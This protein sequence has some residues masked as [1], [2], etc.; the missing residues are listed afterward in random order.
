M[1]LKQLR[2]ERRLNQFESQLLAG[3]HQSRVS[4]LE[5]GL[6]KPTARERERLAKALKV[7]PDDLVFE[8]RKI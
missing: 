7:K 4:L 6:V 2:L 5:R 3:V 8:L 1:D